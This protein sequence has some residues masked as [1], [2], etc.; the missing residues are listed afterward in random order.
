MRK[1]I[2]ALISFATLS[3]LNSCFFTDEEFYRVDPVADDPPQVSVL[4][5]LDTLSNPRVN[6]S[7][8]VSYEVAV[9]NGEFYLMEALVSDGIVHS[10]DT[11]YGSFWVY[12]SQSDETALDTLNMKFYHSSNSNTLADLTGWEARI[13]QRKY[14]IDFSEEV[15]K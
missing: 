2:L 4:S 11:A 3:L 6:D 1:I 15:K 10:S 12:P 8:L 5:N 13:T 14:A 9:V 7:L